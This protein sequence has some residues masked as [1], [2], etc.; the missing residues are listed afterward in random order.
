[1]AIGPQLETRP[2]YPPMTTLETFPFPRPTEDQR[3]LIAVASR[4]LVERRD[5]WLNPPGISEADLAKRTLTNLYNERPQWLLDVHR[6]LD[7]AVLAAYGWAVDLQD[8]ALLARLL[9]LNLSR[10]PA[11]MPPHDGCLVQVTGRSARRSEPLH[12][13]DAGARPARGGV[14]SLSRDVEPAPARRSGLSDGAHRVVRGEPL[15]A[16]PTSGRAP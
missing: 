13:L 3:E 1:M 5:G 4:R 6:H 14:S 7:E 2:R 12:F 16:S 8:D 10:E 11:S 9:A 15:R